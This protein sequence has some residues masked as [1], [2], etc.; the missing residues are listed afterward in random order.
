MRGAHKV[1]PVNRGA[2]LL[3]IQVLAHK[4]QSHLAAALGLN[5]GNLSRYVRGEK[6]PGLRTR[7]LLEDRCGIPV[8]SWDE[9][10]M[11]QDPAA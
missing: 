7:S 6:T 8:R 1:P 5:Q 4:G 10:P 9:P 2:E 3:A 11:Q